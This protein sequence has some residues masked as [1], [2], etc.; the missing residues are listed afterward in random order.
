MA[1]AAFFVLRIEVEL[2]DALVF[3]GNGSPDMGTSDIRPG[4]H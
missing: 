3:L 1:S 2:L 4:S